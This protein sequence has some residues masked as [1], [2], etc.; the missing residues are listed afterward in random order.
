MALFTHEYFGKG[1]AELNPPSAYFSDAILV[2]QVKVLKAEHNKQNN[3]LKS[4]LRAD[5]FVFCQWVNV[6][7]NV[8]LYVKPTQ[9]V[10]DHVNHIY[11]YWT[12]ALTV[13]AC[14]RVVWCG[15]EGS[16]GHSIKSVAGDVSLKEFS[17]FV[18]DK[19]RERESE[20]IELWLDSVIGV[21]GER[22]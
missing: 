13:N 2:K 4:K 22:L 6:F 1:E 19:L 21:A 18:T 7:H 9:E 12:E 14:G 8:A 11:G 20:H 3:E 15:C 17:R 5:G 16:I 10:I